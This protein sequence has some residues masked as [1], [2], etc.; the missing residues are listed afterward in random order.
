MFLPA[1]AR[2]NRCW[3][4]YAGPVPQL[5]GPAAGRAVR[6]MLAAGLVIGTVGG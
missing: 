6:S 3:L 1:R 4:A 5:L 2:E